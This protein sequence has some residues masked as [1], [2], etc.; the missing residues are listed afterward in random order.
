MAKINQIHPLLKFDF[1]YSSNSL[2]FLDTT[3][4]AIPRANFRPRYLKRLSAYLHIK[5][6]ICWSATSK[7]NMNQR[8]WFWSQL[9]YLWNKLI[10]R[11]YKKADIYGSISKTFDRS[12][13]DLLTQNNEP[14][15]RIP[16]T[17]T[18]N[19]PLPNLKEAVKKH[20]K[21]LQMN[22]EFKGVFPEPQIICFCRNKSLKN[23]LWT[24]I[25][26]S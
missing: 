9:W 6:N 7:T 22:S 15:Y 17:L 23:F 8:S 19:C 25:I 11:G 12:K 14:K 1:N 24:E 10:R 16:L 20:W 13:K 21:I 3:G 5:S 4:K 18:S 26:N 2:N